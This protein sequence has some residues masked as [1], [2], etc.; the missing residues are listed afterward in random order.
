MMASDSE[1]A[2]INLILNLVITPIFPNNFELNLLSVLTLQ[3]WI[4][5]KISGHALYSPSAKQ[6]NF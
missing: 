6:T 5:L 1:N 3:L 4:N 2:K